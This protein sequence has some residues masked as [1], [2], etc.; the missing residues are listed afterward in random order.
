MAFVMGGIECALAFGV[1][2]EGVV[3]VGV[4]AVRYGAGIPLPAHRQGVD[5]GDVPGP[6]RFGV[7]GDVEHEPAVLECGVVC[8]VWLLGEAGEQAGLRF[9]P[10]VEEPVA[11]VAAAL[12][13]VDA[14]ER[15]DQFVAVGR[16]ARRDAE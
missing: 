2:V 15:A 8:H 5:D 13:H 10:F 6:V 4:F 14:G 12:T 11:V 3:A 1:G 16:V 7:S 9:G